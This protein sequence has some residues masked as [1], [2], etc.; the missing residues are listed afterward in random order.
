[1]RNN[2]RSNGHGG[3]A[4]GERVPGIPEVNGVL[5]NNYIK[6]NW[7][8]Q[9]MPS[10]ANHF[11]KPGENV[12]ELLM[13][14]YLL[15]DKEANAAALFLNKCRMIHWKEGQEMLLDKLAARR[16]IGGLSMMQLL[17]GWIQQ[18]PQDGFATPI[19]KEPPK[20]QPPAQQEEK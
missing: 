3:A 16:S 2:G 7:Q 14:T 12:R 4:V 1:M 10:L 5:D 11:V 8:Q 20:K 18:F 13:R 19:L 9:D 17:A 6:D 15:D